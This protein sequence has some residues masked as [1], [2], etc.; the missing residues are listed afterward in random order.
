MTQ[1]QIGEVLGKDIRRKMKT[2]WNGALARQPPVRINTIGF[3]YENPDVGAFLGA[4]ART[5]AASSAL[6]RP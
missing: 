3:F 5:R 6:S 1:E 4:G 2:D